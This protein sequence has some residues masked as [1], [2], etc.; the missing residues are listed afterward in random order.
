V[1]KPHSERADGGS[2]GEDETDGAG[3][4]AH[5]AS[6]AAS[7]ATAEYSDARLAIGSIRI[8]AR[9]SIA[10]KSNPLVARLDGRGSLVATL[11]G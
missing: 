11:D 9:S 10:R 4:R 5:A 2:G 6:V 8:C 3:R 7:G 1:H